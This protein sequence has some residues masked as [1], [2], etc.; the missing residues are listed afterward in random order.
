MKRVI[1]LLT[2]ILYLSTMTGCVQQPAARSEAT[3]GLPGEG[4]SGA[5]RPLELSTVSIPYEK[6][7]SLNPF[8]LNTQ[9][10]KAIMP[11][12]YDSLYKVDPN[13]NSIPVIAKSSVNTGNAC[14]VYLRESLKF[15]DGSPIT[16]KDVVYSYELAAASTAYKSSL[17]SIVG[18]KESEQD[19]SVVFALKS[20]DALVN[21]LLTFPIVRQ[22][23]GQQDVPTGSGRYAYTKDA[24][25]PSG[26]SVLPTGSVKTIRLIEVSSRDSF[27]AAIRTGVIDYMFTPLTEAQDYSIGSS[28]SL[29]STNSLVYL[30][31]N[32]NKAYL[33][34]SRVRRGLYMS[35][36]RRDIV[37]RGFM[38]KARPTFTPFNPVVSWLPDVEF[39]DADSGTLA[40]TLFAEVGLEYNSADKYYHDQSGRLNLSLLV[41]KDNPIKISVANRIKNQLEASGIGISLREL[42]YSE[43]TAAVARGEFDLYLG[44]VKLKDNMDISV[45]ITPGFTTSAGVSADQTLLQNYAEL[46]ADSKNVDRF[47]V[48]F[49]DKMPLIPIAYHDGIVAYPRNFSASV[50]A[51]EQDIFYNIDKW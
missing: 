48:D 33:S 37:D 38:G 20:P 28:S 15:T 42:P 46:R 34:D 5:A 8:K 40:R 39:F 24:L 45:L 11:L 12:L 41:N 36:D 26:V 32:S 27:A 21:N 13:Y 1:L 25:L 50:I 4:Q 14:R 3:S 29:V 22:G 6:A 16:P 9:L 7:D 19:G 44:E 2:A 18:A 35:L 51:T 43:Y 47:M 23:T 49:I 30:G 17:S 10:N 31:I